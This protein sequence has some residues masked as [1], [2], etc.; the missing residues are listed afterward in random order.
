MKKLIV[1]LLA[2]LFIMSGYAQEKKVNEQLPAW[3]EGQLDIHFINT[4]RGNSSFLVFPDGTTMLIDAGDMDANEFE[5]TN[6]PLK[7]PPALPDSSLRPGQWIASYIKQVIPAD[8][9]ATIDYALITH[10][11][12]DHYGNIEKNSPKAANGAYQLSGLTDVGDAIPIKH[13]LDR[14]RVYPVDLLTYYRK[15]ATFNNY[16]AFVQYQSGHKGMIYEA[17]KAGSASQ[18]KLL[19]HPQLYPGF[20]VRNIKSNAVIWSGKGDGTRTCFTTDQLLEKGKF[21]ENPLSNAIRISY[22]PFIFYSGGDN[23]GY[24][25]SNYPGRRDVE[26]PMAKI[27]GRVDALTLNHHGNRDATNDAFLKA[28]APKI[29]VEQ[30]WCSDQPGQEVAFRLM[31]KTASEDST[32]VFDTYMQPETKTYLGFWI[33]K[34]FKSFEGHVLIRVSKGGG[35]YFVFILDDRSPLIRVKQI[36]GPYL[37]HHKI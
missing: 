30:S 37:T 5:N 34:G 35:S 17:L 20:E 28:L 15:N 16:L 32:D 33:A 6:A 18:I 23:T 26:T 22:G 2:L 9:Q 29:A 24:E 7:I 19:I 1:M 10:F 14:G 36:F 27:I 3:Q 13:M 4:G 12:G 8:R 11:H 25:G 31:N 21:N